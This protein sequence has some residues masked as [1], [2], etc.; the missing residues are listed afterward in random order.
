MDIKKVR[1]IYKFIY[2]I[3]HSYGVVSVGVSMNYELIPRIRKNPVFFL[4]IPALAAFFIALVPTLKYQWPLSWDIFYHVHI[5]KLY[6]EHG[7]TIWDPLT[8]SPYGR[9]IGYPPLFHFLIAS[10]SIIFKTDPFFVVRLLQPFVAMLMVFS[11][12]FLA[13]RFYGLI[14]GISTGILTN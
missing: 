4:L 3:K 10:L 12:S 13:Y 2:F 6:L 8:C 14:P 5:V 9:T 11:I 1:S 7:L